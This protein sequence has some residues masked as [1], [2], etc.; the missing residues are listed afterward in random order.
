VA[1]RD[2]IV[3]GASAGGVEA[4]IKVMRGLP[5]DLPAAVFV[6]LHMPSDGSSALPAILDRAG[7]L[8]A[9][10][11][12][13]GEPIRAGHVYVAPPDHHLVV[14]PGEVRVVHGPREN[15]HRPAVDRLF[16]SA[17]QAYGPRV[18]GV[19]LSGTMN[20][21]TAGLLAVKRHGGLAVVQDPH[22]AL[23][24][25]MPTSA[26]AYVDVDHVLP[27]VEIG[28]RL[29]ELAR[30]GSAAEGARDMARQFDPPTHDGDDV[31]DTDNITGTGTITPSAFVCPEC[32]GSLWENDDAELIRYR[33]R[34]GHSYTEESLMEDHTTNL[35]G[36]LWTALRLLEENAD[37]SRR[38]ADRSREQGTGAAAAR[39]DERAEE[40]AGQARLIEDAL[41]RLAHPAASNP[42]RG[43]GS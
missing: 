32:G 40:A 39:F 25:G 28:P 11:P 29:A 27:V 20:D 14:H 34:V 2:I 16:R 37:L 7:P 26:L 18:A 12:A 10:H 38:L 13:N 3:V 30:N 43:N 15:R 19:I 36:A 41:R 9:R 23:Y 31:T 6:V 4:L 5:A 42:T 35:E 33:C 8:P 24:S 21:G 22:D 1:N 17:A